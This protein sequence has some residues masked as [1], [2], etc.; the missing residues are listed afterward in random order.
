MATF[1]AAIQAFGP[2]LVYNR[3]ADTAELAQVLSERTGFKHG[4]VL[5]I[6]RELHEVLT[7]YGSIGM[8]VDLDG[9]GRFRPTIGRDGTLRLAVFVDHELA[10]EFNRLDRYEGKIL[11]RANIGLDDAGYKTLWD[12]RYPRD[13]LVL[14]GGRR[15]R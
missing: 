10:R 1:L 14:P 11:N 12:E 13:P 4:Q 8:P 15:R 3:T 6:L 9:I 7:D 2:R 5:L